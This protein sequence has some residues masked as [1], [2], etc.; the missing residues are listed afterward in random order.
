MNIK[1]INNLKEF[2]FSCIYLWTNTIND[3]HYVGQAHNFYNRMSQYKQGFFNKYMKNAINKY[4]IDNFDI[5]ILEK[6]VPYEKLDEREQYWLD[7]Y[8]SYKN[9]KGYNICQYASTTFG[10]KHT[11]ESKRK[12]SDSQKKRMQDENERLKYCGENNG[13]YGKVHTE[14]WKENHSNFLKNKWKTDKDYKNFWK[15]RMSGENN[16]M[17]GVHLYGELNGMYGKKHSDETKKK[18]SE[19]LKGR[20]SSRAKRVQCIET[21]EEF[22]SQAQLAKSLNV[23][24]G[25]ISA[26]INKPNRTCKGKHYINI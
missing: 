6:N 16:H 1:E 25:A 9:D 19:S 3:K 24:V 7:Y 23:Y 17:Y 13:M 11:E 12:M 15:N 18:I 14:E 2:S 26:C 20:K 5:T 21:K 22:D 4:G 8:E 10:Y